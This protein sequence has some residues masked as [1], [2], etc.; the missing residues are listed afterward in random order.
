M[1]DILGQVPLTVRRP[2]A[3][4][5]VDHRYVRGAETSFTILGHVT[6]AT[7]A[8]LVQTLEMDVTRAAHWIET[9]SE[10]RTADE[11]DNTGPDVV[12]VRGHDCEVHKAERLED[13][14]D[15]VLPHWLV[16][17]VRREQ[18]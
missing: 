16:L 5:V 6:D 12:V 9:I 8:E 11:T 1:T 3:G 13:S 14:P 4:S 17:V 10:L 7:P 18:T 15:D 2:A